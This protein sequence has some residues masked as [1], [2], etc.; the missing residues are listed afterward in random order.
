[1]D[2]VR[3]AN[4]LLSESDSSVVGLGCV[5]V[6]VAEVV[7]DCVGFMILSLG[8]WVGPSEVDGDWDRSCVAVATVAEASRDD[9][10]DLVPT[11]NDHSGVSV[12]CVTVFVVDL[13]VSG[14]A[15]SLVRLTDVVIVRLEP[16]CDTVTDADTLPE[17]D[18]EGYDRDPSWEYD[19][20]RP[21]GVGDTVCV[22]Y[23][24]HVALGVNASSMLGVMTTELDGVT[25][26]LVESVAG[27][28]SPVGDLLRQDRLVEREVV[29]SRVAV[30]VGGGVMV[31]VIDK[32]GVS[33]TDTSV[34]C[35]FVGT[36]AVTSLVGLGV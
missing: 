7:V 15:D 20:V 23:G 21:D 34:D 16:S 2:N 1:M 11:V 4:S 10:K 31:G 29:A 28:V 8:V 30:G 14:V 36:L 17:G 33:L 18:A 6:E 19:G 25:V 3:E 35:D 26:M 27:C 5:A 24:D 9:E 12:P 32:N 13:D 22:G